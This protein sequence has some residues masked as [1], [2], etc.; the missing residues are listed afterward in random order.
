[1]RECKNNSLS[2][3]LQRKLQSKV[4]SD[5]PSICTTTFLRASMGRFKCGGRPC[6][7]L[8]QT[9]GKSGKYAHKHFRPHAASASIVRRPSSQTDEPR[10]IESFSCHECLR[11]R[12]TG[13]DDIPLGSQPYSK[14][15]TEILKSRKPTCFPGQFITSSRNGPAC[16]QNFS[17]E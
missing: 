1:M 6:Q 7:L 16:W 17:K 10:R 12:Y 3:L 13:L 9:C 14:A 4:V 5:P 15:G 2:Y 8:I 11:R